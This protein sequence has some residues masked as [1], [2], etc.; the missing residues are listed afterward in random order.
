M[1]R[2]T[3]LTVGLVSA[4]LWG[5]LL[6]TGANSAP[7]GGVPAEGYQ[8]VAPLSSLMRAQAAHLDRVGHLIH[9]DRAEDRFTTLRQEADILAEL[10][11]INAHRAPTEGYRTW[12]ARA[13]DQS[14]ALARTARQGDAG[15]VKA[16]TGRLRATCQGCH[17]A[18][19]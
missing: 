19:R 12:A 17:D 18:H 2:R 7:S 5:L 3:A 8:P 10:S 4:C 1:F 6:V 15:L 9:D 14:L 11:N 13:R 16:R